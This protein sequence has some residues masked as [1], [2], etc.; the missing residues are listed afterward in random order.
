M[1]LSERVKRAAEFSD[2]AREHIHTAYEKDRHRLLAKNGIGLFT[3]GAAQESERIR[4]MIESMTEIV[5]YFF[6][7]TSHEHTDQE[8]ELREKLEEA[9]AEMEKE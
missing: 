2:K 3:C 7:L 6:W 9:L 8:L 4:P 1:S 5:D